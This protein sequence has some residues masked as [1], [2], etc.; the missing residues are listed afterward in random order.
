MSFERVAEF[1]FVTA[2]YAID[3]RGDYGETSYRALRFIDH[4][5]CVVVFVEITSGIQVISFRK[6]NKREVKQ[7]ETQSGND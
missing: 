5:L 4:R 2:Q 1:N 6:A 7:Y 3:N